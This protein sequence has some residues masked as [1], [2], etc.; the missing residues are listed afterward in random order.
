MFETFLNPGFLMAGAALVSLPIIIHL[1]NRMR[2][3][4]VR[5]AAMEFLLKSQ[6]RNRRRLI[7]EQLLLLALRCFLILLAT[8]LVARYLGASF[9]LNEPQ[10][11]FHVVVFDDT[12]SMTDHWRE[13]TEQKDSFKLGKGLIVKEIARNAMQARTHQDLA[14]IFLSDP[15]TVHFN[16]RLNDQSIG[17]LEKIVEDSECTAIRTPLQDGIQAAKEL[18]DKHGKDKCYLHVVSDL[19]QKDWGDPDGAS[20]ATKLQEVARAN[21]KI[22]LID[23]GHPYRND[24]QKTPVYHDNLA[25]IDLRPETRVAAKDMPVQFTVTVANYGV[26]ERKVRV[27]CKVNGGER[28]EG[29]VSMTVRPGQPASDSFQVAFDQLGPNQITA[30]IDNEEVGLQLDNIRYAVVDVRKQV[31]VLIVDGDLVNSLKPG[32][33]AYH[34]QTLLGAARGYQVSRGGPTELDQANLEQY[35]CI[36]LLN[37][38]RLSERGIKNLENYVQGGGS[39]AFFLGHKVDPNFYN[40]FLYRDGQG[41]FP[42]PLAD[43]PFPANT[44][45]ELEPN[46]FDN[47][48]KI[49]VRLPEQPIFAE[50]WQPNLRAVFN[51]LPIK[52]H[53]PVPRQ[54]WSMAPGTVR[55]KVE[56]LVTL[57]NN[58]AM[59][60]YAPRAQALLDKLKLALAEPKAEKYKARL[61]VHEQAIHEAL[62]G[63]K[64]LYELANALQGMLR[65]RG[66]TDKDGKEDP[67]QPNLVDFWNM[68]EFKKL[69]GQF[70]EFREEVQLGDPLV[71]AENFGRGRVVAFLTTAG[72]NWNDWAGG[73]PASVTY[74]AVMVELQ[75]YLTSVGGESTLN[76]GSPLEVTLDGT[77]FDN[78]MLWHYE[79]EQRDSGGPAGDGTKKADGP[80]DPKAAPGQP[81]ENELIARSEPGQKLAF[82]FKGARK[83]GLY[84][85]KFPRRG[86]DSLGGGRSEPEQR[87]YV[88]NLDVSESDLRRSAK[89]EL[90]RMAAPNIVVQNPTPGWGVAL[91]E[92]KNDLSESAWFYL[93]FIVI[94]VIEQALAVHLS[95]HLRGSEAIPATRPLQPKATAA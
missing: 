78:K 82:E 83:P 56:E 27:A 45:P 90:E 17:E 51:F 84:V 4:R 85:F 31:P 62:L 55:G 48:L 26:V 94:L 91:Q 41:I 36:Y 93:L 49:F 13:E 12:P 80:G 5:W 38:D 47:Q 32:G 24:L 52:R 15:T 40:K 35:A 11:T 1:I 61:E 8:M 88:F 58:N 7:I 68:A 75:K 65:D 39:V 54:K 81:K 71:I 60:D 64:P 95:F 30:N 69:G 44:D 92:K 16:K 57:P 10:N 18:L 14:L 67:K 70:D 3:K 21:T 76:V 86:D 37:V 66:I 50:V 73:S 20:L 28:L 74:P 63:D 34:V 23:T 22:F 29:S 2:F 25:I 72:R 89:D 42:A 9:S 59:R 19:R 79:P 77:R 53:F 46:L 6:K 43:K 87:A 33:D